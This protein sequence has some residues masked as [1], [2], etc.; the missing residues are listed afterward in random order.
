MTKPQ[1]RNIYNQKRLAIDSK[2]KLKLDDLML[3]QF[4]NF[5]FDDAVEVLLT[6]WPHMKFA[7]PNVHLFNA[8]ARHMIPNLLICYPVVDVSTHEMKSVEINEDTV[9][10][11]NAFGIHEPVAGDAVD[12][13]SID[14]VFVPMVVCDI[15]GNRVGF[16]KGYYDKYLATCRHDVCKIAFSYF[17]PV[18]AVED[19][20]S[21]DVP[22]SY[23]VTPE[24]IYEF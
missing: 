9:Y 16:G 6:Y 13:L 3:M 11:P 17:E 1:L 24:C 18:D 7:E 22:L 19:A 8:Y 4:Q 20:N 12:P 14:I 2:E 5:V 10:K 21:F 23:C 15:K